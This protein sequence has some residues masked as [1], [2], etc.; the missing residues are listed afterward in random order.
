MTVEIFKSNFQSVVN[1]VFR[2]SISQR[3]MS[4][5]LWNCFSA[6]RLS[7]VFHLLLLFRCACL[8]MELEWEYTGGNPMGMRISHKLGNGNG[9][10]WES[11]A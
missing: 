2:T 9:K 10:E 11:T 1:G 7:T 6:A 3:L 5:F 8:G 4:S